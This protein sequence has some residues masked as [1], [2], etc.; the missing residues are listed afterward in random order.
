VRLLHFG[1]VGPYAIG[2]DD[3]TEAFARVDRKVAFSGVGLEASVL[4]C[5]EDVLQGDTVTDALSVEGSAFS[6]LFGSSTCYILPLFRKVFP[7]RKVFGSRSK[8]PLWRSRGW[9]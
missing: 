6:S 4:K 5:L 8:R 2:R 1:R 7:L 9:P 3:V